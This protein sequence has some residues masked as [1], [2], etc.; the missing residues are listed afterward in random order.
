MPVAVAANQLT[1]TAILNDPSSN[2][3]TFSGAINDPI[4]ATVPPATDSAVGLGAL[5]KT[6]GTVANGTLLST[7]AGTSS[8]PSATNWS[9]KINVTPVSGLPNH[10]ILCVRTGA[11]V[12]L[13]Y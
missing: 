4:A 11:S 1:T 9:V 3:I 5:P 7:P 12:S 6:A 13:A 10:N 2:P 8:T